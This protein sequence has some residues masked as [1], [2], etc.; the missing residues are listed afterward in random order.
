MIEWVLPLVYVLMCIPGYFFTRRVD[1]Y[2]GEAEGAPAIMMA[3]IWPITFIV[4]TFAIATESR[5]KK[6]THLKSIEDRIDKACGR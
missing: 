6:S 3:A 4:G 1:E 5:K 2:L